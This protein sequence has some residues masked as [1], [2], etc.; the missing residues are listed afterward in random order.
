MVYW[1]LFVRRGKTFEFYSSRLLLP[2][3]SSSF[4]HV[5]HVGLF[6]LQPASCPV[7]VRSIQTP[8]KRFWSIMASAL[9]WNCGSQTR[10]LLTVFTSNEQSSCFQN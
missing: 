9:D 10:H 5:Y 8:L 2:R 1:I 4:I 7:Y 3:F 6:Q